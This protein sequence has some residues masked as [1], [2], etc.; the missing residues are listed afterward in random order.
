[1]TPPQA[2]RRRRA[3]TAARRRRRGGGAAARRARA[4]EDALGADPARATCRSRPTAPRARRSA[5]PR[6]HSSGKSLTLTLGARRGALPLARRGRALALERRV[7]RTRHAEKISSASARCACLALRAPRAA[8][9]SCSPRGL[10]LAALPCARRAAS[11]SPHGLALTVRPRARRAASRSQRSLALA[12]RPRTLRASSANALPRRAPR[13][14]ASRAA[15]R[16][17]EDVGETARHIRIRHLKH[18][19]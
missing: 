7:V 1:M 17:G 18:Y 2:R 5:R 9:A 19:E 15:R 3:T 16:R 6:T 12:A 11:R 13:R 4:A 14:R 10:S 8:R